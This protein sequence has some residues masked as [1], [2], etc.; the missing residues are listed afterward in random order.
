MSI[1]NLTPNQVHQNNIKAEKL[2]KNYYVKS[3]ITNNRTKNEL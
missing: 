1:G 3:P 2:W